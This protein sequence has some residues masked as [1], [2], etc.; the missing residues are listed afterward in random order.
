MQFR[1]WYSTFFLTFLFQKSGDP[2]HIYSSRWSLFKIS[3][4]HERPREAET[5]AEG[6]AGP[7]G[8]PDAGLDPGTPGSRPGPKADAQPLSRLGG[9]QDGVYTNFLELVRALGIFFLELC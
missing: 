3:L 5:P 6:E 8:E 1:V 4:V 7:C 9:P 2:S